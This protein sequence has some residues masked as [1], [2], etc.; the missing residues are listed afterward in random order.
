[1]PT[2][3]A[4]ILEI[5]ARNPGQTD[6]ELAERL[7]GPGSPQQAINQEA[8]LLAGRK[9]LIRQKRPDGLIG[10][11]PGDADPTSLEFIARRRRSIA[12]PPLPDFS[13]A[14]ELIAAVSS[15]VRL[16]HPNVVSAFDG[17]V[18]PSI[19]DQKN[20]I[21]LSTAGDRRVLLD[22]NTTPRWAMLWSHGYPTTSHPTGWTFAHVWARPKDRQCYTHLANLA[23]MPEYLASLT[24]KDGPLGAY[25]RYH[26]WIRYGWKPL[27]E[28]EPEKPD[29]YD[30]ISWCYLREEGDPIGFVK[31]RVEEL[32]NE[33]CK[34]LRSLM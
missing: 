5:V 23:M 17:A 33:R 1:L 16:A 14:D 4:Q 12:V 30:A 9:Q 18:F 10:N 3:A 13:H 28:D 27:E 2:L 19:R 31:S 34:L 7:R 6:R 29:G 22:D 15:Y 11:Y 20:R 32:D 21:T 26:S 24:D 8:R 25:L